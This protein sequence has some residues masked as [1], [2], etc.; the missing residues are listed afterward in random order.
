MFIS[1]PPIVEPEFIVINPF[2]SPSSVNEYTPVNPWFSATK[3]KSFSAFILPEYCGLVPCK[4]TSSSTSKL[5]EYCGLVTPIFTSSF[6][7]I[8]VSW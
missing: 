1:I 5:A 2:C 6:T 8:K 7:L 4:F 3:F